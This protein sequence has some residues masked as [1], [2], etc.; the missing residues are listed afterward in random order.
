M[1]CVAPFHQTIRVISPF[2]HARSILCL[3]SVGQKLDSAIASMSP[4]LG[5][6][7]TGVY[8]TPHRV[9]KSLRF[10][11]IYYREYVS[12]CYGFSG[13]LCFDSG[14]PTA[15]LH[16]H[17]SDALIL[18]AFL[19]LWCCQALALIST[20]TQLLLTAVDYCKLLLVKYCKLLANIVNYCK[21]SLTIWSTRRLQGLRPL[22]T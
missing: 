7:I 21:L 2:F 19:L 1:V 18:S 9:A 10:V 12:S 5:L 17:C 22:N 11:I 4:H 3:W 8:S 14:L 6:R 20:A 16:F 13:R 15:R